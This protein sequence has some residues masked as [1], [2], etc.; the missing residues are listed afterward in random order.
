MS[1]NKRL[2]PSRPDHAARRRAVL[3]QAAKQRQT[4]ATLITNP[5]DVGYLTGFTG[6]DSFLLLGKGWTVLITDGRYTEQAARE[7]PDVDI[8]TRTGRM[9][10]A[11]ADCLAGRNVRSLA[12]QADHVTLAMS[13]A[14]G[15]ALGKRKLHGLENLTGPLRQQKDEAEI[16]ILQKAIRI[17]QKAFRELTGRGPGALVG[18]TERQV[19]ADL[20]HL[21]RRHGAEAPSF[22]TIV[23]AGPNGSLPHYRPAEK[24]IKPGEPVLFDFGALLEGYCSDL[25]RVVFTGTIPTKIGTIY[26]VV[27]SAQQAAIAAIKP[28]VAGKTVDAAAREVIAEAGF[29]EQFLH[30]TGHGLGRDVHEAPGL[31]RLGEER[32][33]AGMVLTVEPGI[34]LPGLGGVRIEDDVLVTSDGRRKLSSLPTT[35]DAMRL[36]GK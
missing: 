8:H 33:K 1:P 30:S 14:L 28:G 29:G 9:S 31:S 4:S 6:N 36:Q 22:E 24:K 34:Y 25:T 11:V 7:C 12:L 35:L 17:A 19:A 3:R 2:A 18:H 27:R 26:D 16:R 10:Q 20:D 23:A 13:D 21:M 32:L 15:K 5:Q